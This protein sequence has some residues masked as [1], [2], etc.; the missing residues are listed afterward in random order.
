MTTTTDGTDTVAYKESILRGLV[1]TIELYARHLTPHE[2]D[3]EDAIRHVMNQRV[4]T[5]YE[6]TKSLVLD[7]VLFETYRKRELDIKI[8]QFRKLIDLLKA[9]IMQ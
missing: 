8:E 9:P 1:S 6:E 4:D 2:K 5:L 3:Q 7:K